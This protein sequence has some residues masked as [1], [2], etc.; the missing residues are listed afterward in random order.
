MDRR[1]SVPTKLWINCRYAAAILSG[2]KFVWQSLPRISVFHYNRK[3]TNVNIAGEFLSDHHHFRQ[4]PNWRKQILI[5]QRSFE[6]ILHDNIWLLSSDIAKNV[7]VGTVACA[8]HRQARRSF[9]PFSR[10]RSQA[11]ATKKQTEKWQETLKVKAFGVLSFLRR[12]PPLIS[13]PIRE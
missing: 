9:A 2:M 11:H 1:L 4:S 6:K 8:W 13:I 3:W 12:K 7:T 10:R 5:L